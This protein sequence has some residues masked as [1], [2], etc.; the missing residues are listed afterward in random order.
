MS[1]LRSRL[2]LGETTPLPLPPTTTSWGASTKL[3]VLR[4]G[5]SSAASYQKQPRRTA[6]KPCK[7]MHPCSENRPRPS[8]DL[9][10]ARGRVQNPQNPCLRLFMPLFEPQ[11]RETRRLRIY[12]QVPVPAALCTRPVTTSDTFA[13]LCLHRASLYQLSRQCTRCKSGFRNAQRHSSARC[14]SQKTS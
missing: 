5:L 2:L 7:R 13:L 4:V 11:C 8:Q 12:N 1:T 3:G 10:F 9:I 14:R 6:A